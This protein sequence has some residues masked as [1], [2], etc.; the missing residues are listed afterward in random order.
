MGWFGKAL[1]A[2]RVSMGLN[3]KLRIEIVLLRLF[4][5]RLE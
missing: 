3:E 5:I 2:C 1:I 4:V